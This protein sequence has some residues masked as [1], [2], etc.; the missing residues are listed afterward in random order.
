MKTDFKISYSD[1]VERTIANM[2]LDDMERRRLEMCQGSLDYAEFVID[3]SN[4]TTE[5]P[6]EVFV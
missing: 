6:G 2:A 3:P 5:W 4:K 1:G